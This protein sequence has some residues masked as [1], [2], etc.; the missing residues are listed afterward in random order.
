MD[1]VRPA[2]A[3][4]FYG[5]QK[6]PRQRLD[7]RQ[8][9]PRSCGRSPLKASTRSP[10]SSGNNSHFLKRHHSPVRSYGMTNALKDVNGKHSGGGGDIRAGTPPPQSSNRTWAEA[11]RNNLS[12]EKKFKSISIESEMR[13]RSPTGGLFGDNS[14]FRKTYSR[15]SS[16]GQQSVQL[17][18]RGKYEWRECVRHCKTTFIP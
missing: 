7:A 10:L 17:A 4:N 13:D 12:V 11:R 8:Q 2:A 14:R 6:Q 5:A 3:S 9:T 16:N 18:P 1:T 15:R